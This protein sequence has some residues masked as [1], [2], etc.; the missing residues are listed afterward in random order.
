MREVLVHLADFVLAEV[1]D[2]QVG[3]A[4]D[5]A[6]GDL[7]LPGGQD[8]LGIA[9]ALV[10]PDYQRYVVHFIIYKTKIISGSTPA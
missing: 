5:R 7:D 9:G 8:Q 4:I 10:P 2:G 6:G 1:Q 3:E